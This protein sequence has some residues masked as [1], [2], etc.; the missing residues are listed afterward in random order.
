MLVGKCITFFSTWFFSLD[1]FTLSS[2]FWDLPLA[3]PPFGSFS[4][5]LFHWGPGAIRTSYSVTVTSFSSLA[6]VPH[7]SPLTE[8]RLHVLGSGSAGHCAPD[9]VPSQLSSYTFSNYPTLVCHQILSFIW[10]CLPP[11][12]CCFPPAPIAKLLEIVVY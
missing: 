8:G 11:L 1:S 10:L 12:C 9:S 3:P 6:S 5:A 7:T 2:V 4:A